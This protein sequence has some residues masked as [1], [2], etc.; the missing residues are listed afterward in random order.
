MNRDHF[1]HL[2]RFVPPAVTVLSTSAGLFL[3]V[4]CSVT[5]PLPP[6][7]AFSV[8]RAFH[9]T[10]AD[11]PTVLDNP[12]AVHSPWWSALGDS[13]LDTLI[14]LALRN[15]RDLR[16]AKARIDQARALADFD[17]AVRLPMVGLN[18]QASRARASRNVD[19]PV[20]VTGPPTATARAP[21]LKVA[22][23]T[24]N[25]R[26]R[27]SLDATYEADLWGRLSHEAHASQQRAAASEHDLQV[28][29]LSLTANVITSHRML[30]T[31]QAQAALLEEMVHLGERRL[32]GL[33]ARVS[34][35]LADDSAPDA[36]QISVADNRAQA[37]RMQERIALGRH[38]L[39]LLCGVAP[40]A[41]PVP[42][43]TTAPAALPAALP[44]LSDM[45]STVLLRRPDVR[46]AQAQLDAALSD[47]GAARADFFPTL[48]LTTGAG[49]ESSALAMLLK[50]G[51]AIW[52]LAAQVSSPLFDGGRRNAQFAAARARLDEAAQHYE[53]VVLGVLREVEDAL[54]T[55]SALQAQAAQEALAAEAAL[56][57][58]RQAAE[59]ADTGMDARLGE[60][61]LRQA[62]LQRQ[63]SL[64][65]T[66]AQAFV[67][68]VTLR[69]VLAQP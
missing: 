55:A 64:L 32:S 29:R 26:L 4:G 39:A 41:L 3:L 59:R 11:A 30:K 34:A 54:T 68:Q 19:V 9:A 5:L 40:G 8:P 20:S 58:A 33:R 31:Q 16:V 22:P 25:S 57:R 37:L 23:S 65:D 1:A 60:L 28:A 17:Q 48:K 62:A 21:A 42:A 15:N 24:Y 12:T 47:A 67:A 14:D 63:L 18:Q 53:G 49:T 2:R 35:G 52:S 50:P 36:L 7:P 69:K 43:D 44:T 10:P 45:P 61:E 6:T 38:A 56:R 13:Q 46:S 51:S 27:L 66:H